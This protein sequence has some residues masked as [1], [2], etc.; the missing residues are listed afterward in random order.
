M[1]NQF[2]LQCVLDDL[3]YAGRIKVLLL[4]PKND[5]CGACFGACF[6]AFGPSTAA[7]AIEKGRNGKRVKNIFLLRPATAAAAIE[8]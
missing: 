8:K 1:C 7:A 3:Q 4:R 6:G 2:M 5:Y